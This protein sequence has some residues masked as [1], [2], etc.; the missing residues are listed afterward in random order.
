MKLPRDGGFE[1]V[2]G[3]VLSRI[4]KIPRAG[5]AVDF[6][7]RRFTVQEMD[8]HRIAKVKIEKLQKPVAMQ[9]AGD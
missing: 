6:E 8:D 9:H 2:A 1:T 5:E 4:Q 3:F 7:G